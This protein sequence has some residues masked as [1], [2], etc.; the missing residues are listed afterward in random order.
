MFHPLQEVFHE[1]NR[2]GPLYRPDRALGQRLRKHQRRDGAGRGGSSGRP[3]HLHRAG[4]APRP[5]LGAGRRPLGSRPPL[6]LS[7]RP[8]RPHRLRLLRAL[9][10]SGAA[11]RPGSR[12]RRRR[13]RGGGRDGAHRRQALR[14]LHR[15]GAAGGLLGNAGLPAGARLRPLDTAQRPPLRLEAE[16]AL[17][18]SG[19]LRRGQLL[20][21]R[22]LAQPRGLP[23]AQ[24][25]G[26]GMPPGAGD[27]R[28]SP[29][30]ER[31]HRKGPLPARQ[32][33]FFLCRGFTRG[34]RFR[35]RGPR[36]SWPR[37]SS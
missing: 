18:A 34:W 35:C 5:L 26:G 8:P 14:R 13:L 24:G 10:L 33:P 30:T 27:V 12:R 4:P 3:R 2:F 28:S 37:R 1:K 11:Q 20:V 17:S 6:R 36:S 21:Q 32:R 15:P 23:P 19:R 29:E 31:T 22:P 7:R 25:S 16:R 9:H